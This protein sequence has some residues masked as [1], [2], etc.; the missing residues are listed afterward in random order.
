M[1]AESNRISTKH[2]VEALRALLERVYNA[3]GPDEEIN[4]DIYDIVENKSQ[5][6]NILWIGDCTTSI[7][8]GIDLIERMLPFST[9]IM[10][11]GK[12]LNNE[13]LYS[14]RIFLGMNV[15]SGI[16]ADA[17][18]STIPLAI[19]AAVITALIAISERS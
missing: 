10:S 3:T 7:D 9:W 15:Y 19:C 18:A 12:E 6:T 4:C 13:D 2:D 1:S 14:I 8:H 11:K 5:G 16:L 17:E